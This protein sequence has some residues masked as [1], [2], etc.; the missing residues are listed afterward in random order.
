MG[1]RQ[2][3]GNGGQSSSASQTAG[4]TAHGQLD[5]FLGDDKLTDN[6]QINQSRINRVRFSFFSQAILLS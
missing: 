3:Q 6:G 4:T 1:L 5:E 2:T